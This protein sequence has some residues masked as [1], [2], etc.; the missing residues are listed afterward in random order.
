MVT[1]K[2]IL[3]ELALGPHRAASKVCGLVLV[4]SSY[5]ILRVTTQ[6]SLYTLKVQRSGFWTKSRN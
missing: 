3:A 2:V 6:M 4:V 1:Y 5:E